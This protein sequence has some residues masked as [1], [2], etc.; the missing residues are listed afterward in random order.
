MAK[1]IEREIKRDCMTCKYR[2]TLYAPPPS[3]EKLSICRRFP[4]AT[5]V[6]PTPQGVAVGSS[7]P[8]VAQGAWCYEWTAEQ[9]A[10]KLDG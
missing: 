7:F 9:A 10:N 4:P 1:E 6:M 5:T 3:I 8:T 2:D